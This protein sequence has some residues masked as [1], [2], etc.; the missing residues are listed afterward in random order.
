MPLFLCSQKGSGYW[1]L[2]R[3]GVWFRQILL[4]KGG[5][6]ESL[7]GDQKLETLEGV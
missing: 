6:D 3:R 5:G 7:P 1:E 4:L 2:V